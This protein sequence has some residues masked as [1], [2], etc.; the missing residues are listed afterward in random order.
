MKNIQELH[1]KL[2]VYKKNFTSLHYELIEYKNKFN[3]K[4]N[5]VLTNKLNKSLNE[6]YKIDSRIYSYYIY[7]RDNNTTPILN[8]YLVTDKNL[9][10]NPSSYIKNLKLE[11][12]NLSFKNSEE[13][14][15]LIDLQT[16]LKNLQKEESKILSSLNKLFNNHHK[17]L[18]NFSKKKEKIDLNHHNI[19]VKLRSLIFDIFNKNFLTKS[20]IK[21]KT[22][23]GNK[24]ELWWG[25]ITIENIVE[26]RLIENTPTK[27]YVVEVKEQYPNSKIGTNI[28]NISSLE[29]FYAKFISSNF[30]FL[31]IYDEVEKI[32]NSK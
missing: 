14:Q 1:N 30:E 2:T 32:L 3:L 24:P 19:S 4:I 21:F 23:N 12:S 7:H 22:L 20:P 17:K 18:T 26:I 16:L 11:V 28:I 27:G 5:N 10:E 29:D 25:P 15:T 6:N 8:L 13:F 9:Q 31:Y